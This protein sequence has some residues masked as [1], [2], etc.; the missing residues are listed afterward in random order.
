MFIHIERLIMPWMTSRTIRI[1][2][3]VVIPLIVADCGRS[4]APSST[5][6]TP[7][8]AAPPAPPKLPDVGLY[9]TNEMSG[10]L[11]VID[12]ATLAPVATIPLGKRPRGLAASPDGTR[13]YVALSGSP[14]AGPGVDEKTLPPPDRSAD[15]IGVVDLQQGKLLK[16]LPSGTDPEQLAV[17]FDGT[18]VFIAN[19]DAAKA[20]IVDVATGQI[21]ESFKIGEEPEGV[22]V[23]PPSGGRV[24]VT[25]EEDGAVFV[26]DLAAHKV[27]K[28][29]KVGPR[30]RSV[31]FLPDGSR[32]YVPAENGASLTLIDVKR[33]AP[34]KTIDLGKGMRPM[35]TRMAAD[36]KHLYV[37]TGR[38]KMMLVLD[39]TTNKVVGSVEVGPRP[40]GIALAPDGTTLYTANGPSND[41]SVIDIAARQVTKKIP[42]G[43][44]PWGIA[45]VKRAASDGAAAK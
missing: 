8:A 36:G 30:P 19:E 43:R 1:A 18:R 37:T 3:M 35:G 26:I 22:S 25:S 20:S 5:T 34:L 16:V 10:D 42:V 40:W 7:P 12:A 23:E 28:S 45:L 21:T 29:V 2:L 14:N 17:S 24:W 9:V 38:S 41:V 31:A 32:A 39:T 33:L 11:T 6:S 44:G 27:V 4:E 15:G 13:L